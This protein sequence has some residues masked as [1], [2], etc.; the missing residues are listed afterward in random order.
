VRSAAV[1]ISRRVEERMPD[2]ATAEFRIAK[3]GG[4]VF[5]DPG[6]NAPGAHVVAPYSPRARPGATVSF[7]VP[8]TDLDQ[9][10]PG[11]FTIRNV[12]GLLAKLDPWKKLMPR[13]QA[14][15][16]DLHPSG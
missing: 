6:R 12:P 16:G 13:P 11:D 14:I 9:V 8:W 3:R 4:R 1:A 2:G 15:P 10:K 7:P 5:L